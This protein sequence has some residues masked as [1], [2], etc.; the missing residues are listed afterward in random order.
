MLK[1][2]VIVAWR[3]LLRHRVLSLIN[4]LSLAVGIACCSL[5]FLYVS[6][7]LQHDQFHEKGERLYR[8]VL[9]HPPIPQLGNYLGKTLLPHE[10]TKILES[11][12][13]GVVR[14]SGYVTTRPRISLADASFEEEVALVDGDFLEM[15]SFP[16]LA[17]DA[18]S[19]LQGPNSIVISRLMARKLFDV[20]EDFVSVV[21]QTLTLPGV[22]HDFTITGV[23]EEVPVSSSLR[24]DAL[25]RIPEEGMNRFMINTSLWGETTIYVELDHD[26]SLAQIEE[27]M[28]T[29]I[30][31]HLRQRLAWARQMMAAMGSGGAS[32]PDVIGGC[33]IQLQ[34]IEDI[35]LNRDIDSNYV[36]A[37]DSSTSLILGGIAFL[38]LVVACIN[39]VALSLGRSTSRALE[40]GIRKVIGARKDQIM[41]Q[42]WGE[43][44]IVC[45][46][47]IALGIGM[48]ELFLPVFNQLSWRQLHLADLVG[49][50]GFL[51]GAGI[52]LFT[53]LTAGAYPAVVLSRL[54]PVA[55][56][57]E[58]ANLGVRSRLTKFL[59]VLQYGAATGLIVCTAVMI[60]Q[61][62]FMR[63][64]EV[65]YEQDQVV[66]V[67]VHNQEM[68][69][70]FKNRISS[71][72]GVMGVAGSDRSFTS[73]WQKREIGR[74]GGGSQT[75]RAIRV[76]ADYISTL[77]LELLQGR[78]F[79]SAREAE[80]KHA[81]VVNE[82]L[83]NIMGWQENPIGRV[84]EGLVE[85]DEEPDP[86]VIGVVRD[87]HID[88]LR[89]TVEPLVLSMNPRIHGI[90]YVFVRLRANRLAETLAFL[91]ESWKTVVNDEPFQHSVLRDSLERQYTGEE[92]WAKI[93]AYSA[94]LVIFISSLGLLGQ[95]SIAVARRAREIG[96][97]KVHG[98]TAPEL[99]KLLSGETV[100]LIAVANI[101]AWPFSY[102]F[103][104]Q[105]LQHF[106]YRIDMGVS[107]Y[108]LGAATTLAV[109]LA[110]TSFHSVRAAHVVPVETL[111]HKQ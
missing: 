18:G 25:I 85:G 97:R 98:A 59:L 19:V 53:G 70:R 79:D 108:L 74:E 87:F 60:E 91:E 64:K 111:R 52:L 71:Y 1:S 8:V 65:G 81:V 44:L 51:F 13:P 35:Y 15:F 66:I 75:V 104:G 106:A 68:S 105:W 34:P 84:L 56:F 92:H 29:L 58:K 72:S 78:G 14:G 73:G 40:V 102:Y 31:P 46:L 80:V 2:Y 17:G 22:G 20:E 61:W 67:A 83:V 45:L 16:V 94:I 82:T 39:F 6:F 5:I 69:E 55:M 88:S 90:Y 38:I 4:V 27:A 32:I 47:A 48:A 100:K 43:T 11:E 10:L 50:T 109:S 12:I 9:V 24:F 76:D 36:G 23:I 3:N 21:G 54:R 89:K 28:T 42:F 99:V 41:G 7:E 103:M 86:V 30:E 110:T 107:F 62:R 96:I 33:H 101:L 49:W 95:V 26:Q 37:G 63:D 57:K 93:M 77:G